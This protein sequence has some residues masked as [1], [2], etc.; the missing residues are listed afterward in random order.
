M[1][2]LMKLALMLGIIIVLIMYVV[3]MRGNTK[4]VEQIEFETYI[5]KANDTLWDIARTKY[6]RQKYC[7]SC[8]YY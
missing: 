8:L 1:K 2:R 5:I 6:T 7:R 4:K 3:I